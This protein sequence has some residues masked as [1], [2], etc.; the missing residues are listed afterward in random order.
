MGAEFDRELEGGE[1]LV[2]EGS[3]MKS[4]KPFARAQEAAACVFELIYFARPDSMVFG[5]GVQA[6][7][8]A[9]GRELAIQMRPVKAD[10]IVPVPDSGFSAALGLSQESGIPLEMGL[11]R[12][13]YIGRTFIQPAQVLRDNSV[14]LKLS[15][16]KEALRGKRIVLVDDSI[17]R[18]TTSRRLCRSLRKAGVAEIHMAISS[19]PI[20]SPCYYGIDTPRKSELI[21][22]NKTVDEIRKFLGVDSLTY[23]SLEGTLRACRGQTQGTF[24]SACFTGEYPT[25]LRDLQAEEEGAAS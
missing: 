16:V 9:L 11:I 1:M 5:R 20:V 17:V 19:P 8:R 3:S 4:L 10:V 2:V 13:R 25:R 7:R 23:L 14:N 18:G 22:A 6:A 24:C 15:P 21:A 12:S